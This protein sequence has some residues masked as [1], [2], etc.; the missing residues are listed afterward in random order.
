MSYVRKNGSGGVRAEV[1]DVWGH[2]TV[3]Q[4]EYKQRGRSIT[5]ARAIKL[6]KQR[7]RV[8]SAKP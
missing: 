8:R 2:A 6:A 4:D 5:R 3:I 1:L 7:L